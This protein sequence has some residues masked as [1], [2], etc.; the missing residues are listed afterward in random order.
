MDEAKK[1]KKPIVCYYTI[2]LLVLM[3]FNFLAMPMMGRRPIQNTDYNTFVSMLESGEVG[4]VQLQLQPE[5]NRLLFTD[6]EGK[7]ST[8]QPS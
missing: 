8:R 4:Q 1:P 7:P 3:L 6:K 2:V 5:E